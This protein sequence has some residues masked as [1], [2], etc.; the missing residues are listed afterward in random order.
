MRV[1][2]KTILTTFLLALV[3]GM[4]TSGMA[5]FGTNDQ[6]AFR[7]ILDRTTKRLARKLPTKGRSW[8][9]ARKLLNIFLRDSLYTGYLSRAYGLRAAEHFFEVPLDSITGKQIHKRVHE[10][11]RWKGVRQVSPE[12]SAAYQAAALLLA[13][14]QGV[15]RVHLDAIWWG[16]RGE[17][18]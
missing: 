7:H 9:L 10:V 16:Q 15:S 3:A 8:G 14:K 13:R 18:T 5:Q 2:R 1:I 4:A 6:V 11:S 17:R 12:I